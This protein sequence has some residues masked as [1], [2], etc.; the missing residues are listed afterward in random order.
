LLNQPDAKQKVFSR[1]SGRTIIGDCGSRAIR[2]SRNI[3][4]RSPLVSHK[5]FGRQDDCKINTAQIEANIDLTITAATLV[6]LLFLA[7]TFAS[8]QGRLIAATT[9]RQST[10]I[11]TFATLVRCKRLS[12]SMAAV[13]ATVIAQ[14]ETAAEQRNDQNPSNANPIAQADRSLGEWF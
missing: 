2:Q 8:P 1:A 6:R 12:K 9:I 10:L 4:N 3:A 13:T 11:A 7:R 5:H 14:T